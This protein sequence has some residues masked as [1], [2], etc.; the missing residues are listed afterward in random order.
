MTE[1]IDEPVK[2]FLLS[3]DVITTTLDKNNDVNSTWRLPIIIKYASK[4]S[5]KV[6]EEHCILASVNDAS[7]VIDIF[8]QIEE[9]TIFKNGQILDLKS[10]DFSIITDAS[11]AMRGKLLDFLK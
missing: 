11:P 6:I 8:R 1:N 3:S 2:N 7:K 9:F 4:N 5:S 10:K